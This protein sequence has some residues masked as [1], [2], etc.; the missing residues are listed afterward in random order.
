MVWIYGGGYQFGSSGDPTYDGARLAGEG[1]VVVVTF[2][3]RI[4]V[5][6][7]GLLEGARPTAVCSTRSPRWSGC[8]RT[9]PRSAA[10]R[11]R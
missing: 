2:N 4:G 9:S 8:A 5:D 3:H 1:G 6:G 10:T 11:L 7:F